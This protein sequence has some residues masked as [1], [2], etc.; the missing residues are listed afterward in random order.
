MMHDM[1]WISTGMP[2]EIL[3]LAIDQFVDSEDQLHDSQIFGKE[4]YKS[5]R[6]SQQYW[7]PEHHWFCGFM[8]H[9]KD[10]ANRNFKYDLEP[11][12]HGH[13]IQYTV[14][15]PGNKFDW[16]EDQQDKSDPSI[17]KLAFSVQLSDDHE[18]EGGDL[19]FWHHQETF[20]AP[21]ARGTIVFF[22]TRLIHRVRKI[23]SGTRRALVGW[24]GGPPWK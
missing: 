11:N 6:Q 23:K 13:N 15:G 19:Q 2:K 4:E 21:R 17:R 5:K 7:V 3:D 18:Y 12:I 16:H 10:L 24:Y 8:N 22:D 1:I 9:Y 20:F 14:Y